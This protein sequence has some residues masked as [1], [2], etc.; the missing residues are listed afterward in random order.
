MKLLHDLEIRLLSYI[1]NV[2]HLPASAQ[3]WL[4]QNVWWIVLIGVIISALAALFSLLAIFGLIALLNSP[5][6]VYYVYGSGVTSYMVVTSFVGLAF[7]IA[8]LLLSA[9]AIQPLQRREKKGWVLLFAAWLVSVVSIIVGAI[10][11]LNPV[12]FIFSLLVGALVTGVSGYFLFE[13]H[14]QFGHSAKPAKTVKK[15]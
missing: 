14:S 5:Q 9:F 11:T 15:A 10:L 13:I 1:K 2:P 8:T 7:S 4:G 12:S 6:N 3:K